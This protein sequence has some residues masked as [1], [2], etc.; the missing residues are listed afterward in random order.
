LIRRKHHKLKMMP[1]QNRPVFPNCRRQAPSPYWHHPNHRVLVSF[2]RTYFEVEDIRPGEDELSEYTFEIFESI[3][4]GL[5]IPKELN[6]KILQY[7][8]GKDLLRFSMASK[9]ALWNVE[10]SHALMYDAIHERIEDLVK[11]LRSSR[12]WT[13]RQPNKHKYRVGNC[14]RVCNFENGYVVRVTPKIVF[15]VTKTDIFKSQP[16]VRRIGNDDGVK[17]MRPYYATVPMEFVKNWCTWSGLNVE[18]PYR[19]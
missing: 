2:P 18:F 10:F 16:Q 7:L 19:D 12:G 1:N 8:P 13:Q 3:D 4:G 6:W 14:V 17:P 9:R 5:T 11:E 15:Y